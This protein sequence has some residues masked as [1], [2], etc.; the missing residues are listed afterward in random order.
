V[1]AFERSKVENLDVEVTEEEVRKAI[2][3]MAPNKAPGL[4]GIMSGVLRKS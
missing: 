1:S 3:R 4:D 2:W